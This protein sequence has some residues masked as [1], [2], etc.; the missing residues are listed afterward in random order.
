[1]GLE[2]VLIDG[3]YLYLCPDRYA[4]LYDDLDLFGRGHRSLRDDDV[5]HQIGT[6]VY[7]P[8]PEGY[9]YP[10]VYYWRRDVVYWMSVWDFEKFVLIYRV[11]IDM[12]Y[13]HTP[14]MRTLRCLSIIIYP[15]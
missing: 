6:L 8:D 5:Y 13:D 3:R 1:M 12:M 11:D 2:S 15:K 9:H 4:Q 7:R 14:L 10:V